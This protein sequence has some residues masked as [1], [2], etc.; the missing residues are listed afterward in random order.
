MSTAA[1]E[2]AFDPSS[3]L[4]ARLEGLIADWAHLYPVP[5]WLPN[6]ATTMAHLIEDEVIHNTID[7]EGLFGEENTDD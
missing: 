3:S 7:L 4:A 2:D 5:D 1:V 6:L